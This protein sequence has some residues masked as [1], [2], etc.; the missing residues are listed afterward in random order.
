MLMGLGQPPAT[1]GTAI[2]RT[3]DLKMSKSRPDSA[4]FM[5]DSAQEIKRK[6]GKAYCPEKVIEENPIV[7]YCRYLVFERQESLLLERP[8]KFGGNLELTSFDD[9]A[10]HYRAGAVHP[11]DLKNAVAKAIDGMVAPVREHFERNQKAR[12]LMEEVKSFEVTR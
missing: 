6:I 7:E 3:I 10:R 11:M 12:K 2:D 8:E 9:L 5:T 1:E 4:I